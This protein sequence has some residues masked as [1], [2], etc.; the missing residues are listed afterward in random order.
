MKS[1]FL[2]ATILAFVTIFT[3]SCSKDDSSSTTETNTSGG[4]TISTWAKFT[5]ATPTGVIKPNYIVM[6]YDQPFSPTATMPTIIK[7][8]TTDANG[9][10]NFDLNTIV[11]TSTPKKYYFEVFTQ[12]GSDYIL[13]TTFSR[14]DSDFSKGSHLTTTLLVNN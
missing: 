13:K 14:F 7:Q 3:I 11:T 12:S 9:L 10:A 5:V 1:I 4:T 8:V 2:K 6:M